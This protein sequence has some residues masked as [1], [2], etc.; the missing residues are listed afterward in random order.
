MLGW[1]WMREPLTAH[2]F[3]CLLLLANQDEGWVHNGMQL[4]AGQLITSLDKLMLRTGLTK[5]ELRTRLERLRLSGE[6]EVLSTN[7]GTLISIVNYSLY[8]YVEST[9]GTQNGTRLGTRLGTR[10]TA[11]KNTI[12]NACN[13]VSENKGTQNGTRLGTQNGTRTENGQNQPKIGAH[14]TA[15]KTAHENEQL[16]NNDTASC[17]DEIKAMG[18]QNGTEMGTIQYSIF[19]NQNYKEK[20]QT[21]KECPYTIAELE[22]MFEAFRKAYKGTKRGFKVE[23]DNFKKKH[24]QDWKEIVPLLMPALVNMEAWREEQQAAG[25][26][27]PQYAMLQTWLNQNRWTTEYETTT[28]KED[29]GTTEIAG[30]NGKDA[31]YIPN[32]EEQ[33]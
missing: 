19:N 3:T 26:F 15:H 2:L 13:G 4:H 33:F 11:V 14:K 10:K 20:K 17:N 30:D 1:E 12:P 25:Q 22:Q 28:K 27:V 23:F 16:N 7:Q 21:K 24:Q 5:K 32:Y 29:N 6:L 18:T 8:Q 31:K 9:E